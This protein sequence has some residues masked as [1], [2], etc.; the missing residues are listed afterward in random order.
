MKHR[1]VS[2]LGLACALA[3][4]AESESYLV[5]D[6]R[7]PEGT[8]GM[9]SAFEVRRN[10]GLPL[11]DVAS[12]DSDRRR[13]IAIHAVGDDEVGAELEIELRVCADARAEECGQPTTLE[14]SHGFERGKTTR[15]CVEL[16]DP[17]AGR[18]PQFELDAETLPEGLSRDC[19]P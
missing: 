1:A 3:S 18:L 10:S 16:T 13:R 17:P 19:E 8:A 6:V 7:C 12:I 11:K 15:L 14:L 2:A 4:C 9:F 5:L